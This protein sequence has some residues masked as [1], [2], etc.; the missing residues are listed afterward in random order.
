MKYSV[1]NLKDSDDLRF[2]VYEVP[3]FDHYSILLPSKSINPGAAVNGLHLTLSYTFD[4]EVQGRSQ[5]GCDI[6]ITAVNREI[7]RDELDGEE[8]KAFKVYKNQ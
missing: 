4:R 6:S 8:C 5:E 3:G 1:T 7:P 2:C